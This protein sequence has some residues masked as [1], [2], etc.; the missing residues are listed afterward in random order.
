MTDTTT[1]SPNGKTTAPTKAVGVSGVVTQGGVLVSS[2]YDRAWKGVERDRTIQHMIDDPVIGS[3]LHGVEMLVRRVDWHVKPADESTAAED[4]AQFVQECLDDMTGHWPGDTLA[5]VLT[6]LGWG[7]SCL[8]IV[9]K[10]RAGMGGTPPSRF[11]DGKTG[12]HRWALRPQPTRYG[13]EFVGD[14]PTALIQQDPAT[15]RRITIPL[16]KCLLFRYSSRDNSPEGNTPL[17]VAYDAWYNKRKLQRIEA[18][19]IERDLAGLPVG[20]VPSRDI[21]GNTDV[22][23]A[24]QAIVTN[25]RN[26]AQGGLVI[27]SERDDSGN[28][29]QDV[30]LMATGGAKAIPTDPI[31]KRYANEVV[32]VF[33]ANVMRTGQDSTGSYALA[34]TQGG[35]FQQA[36]GAHLDT[37]A[38]TINEQAVVPLCRLNGIPEELIPTL[39]HGNIESANLEEMGRYITVLASTGA[40]VMTPELRFFLA[41]IAGLPV[42]SVEEI[43]AQQAEEEAEA[44]AAEQARMDA[45]QAAQDAQ[46]A[47]AGE[48]AENVTPMPQRG[49]QAAVAASEVRR[50]VEDDGSVTLSDILQVMTWFDSVVEP[51]HRG[52]LNAKVIG[53]G[54]EE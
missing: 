9:F 12:W 7:W 27:S 23:Q 54:G 34:E 49:A 22:Y 3:V 10:Q 38:Q 32:T 13:W 46:G 44:A 40:I 19:G 11:D 35:L 6:Y 37:I 28:Y 18:I 5:A 4:A 31:I 8:E 17:R 24:M 47:Q 16:A 29:Y 33:L 1:I 43:E 39:E 26:D 2:D 15:F 21:A 30:T 52:L 41:T 36:I 53:E 48:G 45:L 50:L 20:R 14:D 42:P 51:E 25:I